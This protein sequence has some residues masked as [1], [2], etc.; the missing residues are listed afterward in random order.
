MTEQDEQ[1]ISQFE[2]M[3][4]KPPDS[5]EYELCPVMFNLG[6]DLEFFIKAQEIEFAGEKLTGLLLEG[7]ENMVIINMTFE[8]FAELFK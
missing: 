5:D 3:G 2:S 1:L 6:K 4:I 8:K 7:E